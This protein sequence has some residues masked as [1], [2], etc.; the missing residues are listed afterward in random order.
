MILNK[1][2]NTVTHEWYIEDNAI[3]DWDAYI[4]PYL[5]EVSE[6]TPWMAS[7]KRIKRYGSRIACEREFIPAVRA[8]TF[9]VSTLVSCP[10]EPARGWSWAFLRLCCVCKGLSRSAH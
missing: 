9:L 3:V 5:K 2:T 8:G 7:I 10:G 6:K 4:L 1:K